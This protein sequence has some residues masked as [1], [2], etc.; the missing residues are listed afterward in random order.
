M[1]PHKH[2]LFTTREL[3]EFQS[4]Y[5]YPAQPNLGFD[6]IANTHPE[7]AE[8]VA[9][10]L[11]RYW[12]VYQKAV[13]E[14]A[15]KIVEIVELGPGTGFF[16]SILVEKLREAGLTYHYTVVDL[17][18]RVAEFSE[19]LGLD[20]VLSSFEAFALQRTDPIDFL[21]SNQTLD[22]WAGEHFIVGSD[23]SFKVRWLLRD[24]IH[25]LTYSS[26]VFS[27][28]RSIPE[29]AHR[30]YWEKIWVDEQDGTV[31]QPPASQEAYANSHI[32]TP[33]GLIK[34]FQLTRVG[35]FIQD[36]W[37]C[38]DE[39]NPLRA[40][41]HLTDCQEALS[42][43]PNTP[44]LSYFTEAINRSEQA[45]QK[46]LLIGGIEVSSKELEPLAIWFDSPCIPFGRVD[47]TYSPN[48]DEVVAVIADKGFF[49]EVMDIAILVEKVLGRRATEAF[50]NWG[51]ERKV[52]LFENSVLQGYFI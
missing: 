20:F 25:D 35:G 36:Y 41:F 15:D 49:P 37:S 43:Y 4:I 40:G 30:W 23:E 48:L 21:I 26:K 38:P 32:S 10:L 12:R 34:L 7:Y 28:R 14:K 45:R 8:V 42:L 22:M 16:T 51:S 33:S 31:T 47:V 2:Q 9:E 19:M 13:G 50:M 46:Q 1:P 52:I 24:P 27:N 17:N 3:I 39:P 29:G 11:L 44:V 5:Y 18:H 6:S